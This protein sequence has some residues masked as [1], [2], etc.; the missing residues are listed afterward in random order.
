MVGGLHDGEQGATFPLFYAAAA[1]LPATT[2]AYYDA[3]LEPLFD[4]LG[5]HIKPAALGASALVA[6][7]VAADAAAALGLA[8]FAGAAPV[9]LLVL[10]AAALRSRKAWGRVRRRRYFMRAVLADRR[11]GGNS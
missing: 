7:F 5:A 1:A 3:V 2:Q 4:A 6:P 10:G 9:A 11:L 8:A